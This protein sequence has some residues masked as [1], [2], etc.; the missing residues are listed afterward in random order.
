MPLLAGDGGD[1]QEEPLACFVSHG[2]LAELDFHSVWF[3][4]VCVCAT[5]L[6]IN[7]YHMDGER[8][9]R[10]WYLFDS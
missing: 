9:G 8:L 1:L 6:D 10:S 3:S 4:L 7:A 2:G 5:F